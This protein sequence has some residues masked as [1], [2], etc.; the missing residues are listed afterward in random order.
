M[1]YPLP[2]HPVRLT[3]RI[4]LARAGSR[5]GQAGAEVFSC[6]GA[7]GG[8]GP[9]QAAWR[10]GGPGWRRW[11]RALVVPGVGLGWRGGWCVRGRV[12]RGRGA[13]RRCGGSNLLHLL[14][15]RGNIHAPIM[16]RGCNRVRTPVRFDESDVD[17]RTSLTS[18]LT[19]SST[20]RSVPSRARRRTTKMRH[21]RRCPLARPD[22]RGHQWSRPGVCTRRNRRRVDESRPRQTMRTRRS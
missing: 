14:D 4:R 22:R 19:S 16:I 8:F 1:T 20:E 3:V 15:D 12:R 10:L 11:S 13:R 6:Q 5:R 2:V 7:L 18:R 17:G 9:P 21:C